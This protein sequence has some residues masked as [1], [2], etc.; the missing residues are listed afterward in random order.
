MHELSIALSIIDEIEEQ[1][2]RHEGAAVD[3]IYLRIGVLS[4]VDVQAL[5]FAWELA[6]ENTPFASSRLEVERVALL[7]Y[8]PQC[9]TTHRPSP[10]NIACPRCM[11]P[12]QEIIEGRELEVRALELAA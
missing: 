7:V 8:C 6:S 3:A 11:T 9:S 2:Q 12:E 1:V 10:Q 5:R 4:G